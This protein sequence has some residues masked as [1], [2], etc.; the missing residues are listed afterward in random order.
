[1]LWC[2]A[3]HRQMLGRQS[4]RPGKRQKK[5]L[6]EKSIFTFEV[7]VLFVFY[8]ML[9]PYLFWCKKN[10]YPVLLVK[11]VPQEDALIVCFKSTQ[12]LGHPSWRVGTLSWQS[13]GGGPSGGLLAHPLSWLSAPASGPLPSLLHLLLACLRVTDLAVSSTQTPTPKS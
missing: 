9:F 13:A 7:Q 4:L 8:S 5:D 12:H 1:M 3:S 2:R 10:L 6:Q 11:L